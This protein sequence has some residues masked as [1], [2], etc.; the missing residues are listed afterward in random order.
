MRRKLTLRQVGIAF[1]S[2]LPTFGL[3][4]VVLGSIFFGIATP[5]EASGLGAAGA[6]VLAAANRN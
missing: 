3:I 1:L 2:T 5:T 6:I 4:L